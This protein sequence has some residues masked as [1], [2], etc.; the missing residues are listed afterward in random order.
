[1]VPSGGLPG[2]F[3][4]YVKTTAGTSAATA[5][6]V[7]TFVA[8]APEIEFLSPSSGPMDSTT[9]FEI[10]GSGFA[11][12]AK[13]FIGQGPGKP[14]LVAPVSSVSVDGAFIEATAPPSALLGKFPVSVRQAGVNATVE[15]PLFDKFF[16]TAPPAITGVSPNTASTSS[17][18]PIVVTGSGFA[19]S[20][21]VTVSQGTSPALHASVESVSTDG[22]EI[23]ATVPAGG[24]V[25][26]WRVTVHEVGGMSP[27]TRADLF[28]IT[29]DAIAD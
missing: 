17:T 15:N 18:T 24:A 13:V 2:K 20:A 25:G 7:F 8:A 5:A 26:T 21:T 14:R 28:A 29:S 27:A 4:V 1:M 12:G 6:G 11:P 23:H 19:S 16:Y 22:T 9:D 3:K 10:A